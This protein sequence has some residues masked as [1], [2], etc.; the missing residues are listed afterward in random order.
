MKFRKQQN[1]LQ[2]PGHNLLLQITGG[3]LFLEHPSSPPYLAVSGVQMSPP[4]SSIQLEGVSSVLFRTPIAPVPTSATE[5][6]TCG[7]P[8]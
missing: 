3:L 6:N 2:L 5:Q 1:Y 7:L 8:N 4:F